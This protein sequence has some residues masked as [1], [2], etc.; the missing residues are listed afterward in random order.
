MLESLHGVHKYD[1]CI[2]LNKQERK[3]IQSNKR[4]IEGIISM[5][6]YAMASDALRNGLDAPPNNHTL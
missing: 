2:K 5:P 1:V 3:L 6:S 4:K